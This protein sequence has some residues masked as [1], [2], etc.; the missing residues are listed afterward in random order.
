MNKQLFQQYITL[1]SQLDNLELEREH[2]RTQIVSEITTSGAKAVKLNDYNFMIMER[3]KWI[4]SPAI[5]S[6][7]EA[8]KEERHKE[9]ATGVAQ[10]TTQE[11]LLV[12][13]H[14]AY[15]NGSEI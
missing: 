10:Y 12:R 14:T 6:L 13:K 8:L 15:D 1:Q 2:L 4:Y 7:E 3:K 5:K 11:T 9:E